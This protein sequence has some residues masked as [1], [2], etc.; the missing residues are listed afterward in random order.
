[1]WCP[2]E[3]GS[4]PA[5]LPEA[6]PYPVWRL[7]AAEEPDDRLDDCL[8][9]RPQ[10]RRSD[11]L[12]TVHQFAP[13]PPLPPCLPTF[14]SARMP[15]HL[16]A[17]PLT[18]LT[19][20]AGR[21]LAGRPAAHLHSGIGP[22][23]HEAEAILPSLLP[24]SPPACSEKDSGGM[25]SA[26]AG[27]SSSLVM[28]RCSGPVATF[29]GPD[30]PRAPFPGLPLPAGQRRRSRPS[31]SLYREEAAPPLRSRILQER[32]VIRSIR[33]GENYRVE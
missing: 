24:G 13:R 16:S 2:G 5:G 6:L 8:D 25:R 12:Q 27:L 3:E 28:P 14:D 30:N 26:G 31:P 22:P 21:S 19:R 23:R 20:A 29:W 17:P 9:R 7:P 1:M 15:Y 32:S 11:H 10:H 33:P 4:A 18:G